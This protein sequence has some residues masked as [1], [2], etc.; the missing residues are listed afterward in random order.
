MKVVLKVGMKIIVVLL[1]KLF[2]ILKYI[3]NKFILFIYLY[4]YYNKIKY[5]F[6]SFNFEYF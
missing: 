3:I 1:K 2:N 4:F 6:F 5:I